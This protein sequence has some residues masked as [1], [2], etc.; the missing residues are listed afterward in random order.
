MKPEKAISAM[1][2]AVREQD[3]QRHAVLVRLAKIIGQLRG[4][5]RMMEEGKRGLPLLM[6]CA[7][8]DA[9]LASVMRLLA[10]NEV[11]VRASS[12]T[13]QVQNIDYLRRMMLTLLE[14]EKLPGDPEDTYSG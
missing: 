4:A 7:A 5:R 10:Q 9:A 12:G 2:G 11:R 13:D 6:L 14:P 3:A 8:A 1:C